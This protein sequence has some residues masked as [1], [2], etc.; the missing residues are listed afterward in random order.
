MDVRI[1]QWC[2]IDRLCDLNASYGLLES[3][4]SDIGKSKKYVPQSIW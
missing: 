3:Q 4:E 2:E 1:L